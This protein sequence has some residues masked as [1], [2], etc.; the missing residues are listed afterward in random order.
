MKLV[1]R[2]LVLLAALVGF[3]IVACA[4]YVASRQHL[5]F[6]APYPPVAASTDSAVIERGRYVVRDVA[7]CTGCH[8]DAKQFADYESG[9]DTPLSGGV[10]FNIPP[11]TFYARNLTPDPE[12][13]LGG[14]P[15]GAIARA[16]RFGVGH[17]GRALLPF[18]T[19]QGL[20]DEDLAAVVSY[21]RSQPAVKNAVPAHRYNLLGMVVR[22]TV[23]AK[24]V[25]PSGKPPETSPRGAT[26]ENGRYLVERVADCGGRHTQHDSNTGALVGPA[27]GGAT[28]LEDPG[29]PK[30][31][32]SPPNITGDPAT[33]RLARFGEEEFLSRIR[34]GR[35]IPGSPMPWQA[36]QKMSD[37]D[38]R[39]IFRF[40]QT[41]PNAGREVGPPFVDRR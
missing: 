27:L 6:A 40:L 37:E 7:V 15:D 25:G 3:V 1:G 39:A 35:V 36:Y 5:T 4:L 41:V 14:V 9:A 13:G 16:L 24:P 26:I 28:G 12:T 31:F 20:S 19:M 23:L 30:R 29:N 2:L 22:A 10:A 18:M 17:D 38:L 21:L 11:G 32:W 8:G 33:G 34:A